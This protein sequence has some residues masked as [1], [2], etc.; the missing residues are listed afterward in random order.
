[1]RGALIGC[2]FFARNHMHAWAAL[3]GAE[4]V[5]VCDRDRAKAEAMAARFGIEGVH[6]DAAAMF[7]AL[8]LDFADVAT[9]APSH[10]PLVTLAAGHVSTVICQKPFA[11]A[12]EDAEAMVAA[13]DRA[14]AHLIVHEN[15]RWQAPLMRLKAL[16][17]AGR[18]GAPHWARVTFRHGYDNYRNQPYLMEVERFAIMD[19]GLHLFDVARWLMGEAAVTG[20]LT[21]RRNPRVAGEDAF[22][23]LLAHDRGGVSVCD[24]SFASTLDPEPFPGVGC[25]VE[26]PDGTL[27]LTAAGVLTIHGPGARR[28]EDLDPPVPPWGGR[29]WHV[30]QDSVASFQA[31]ALAVMRGEARPQPSGADNLATLRLAFDAYALAGAPRRAAP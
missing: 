6:D 31:H 25:T 30:V 17:D 2:G 19:V 7:D 15:F 13:C 1:M 5:A 3:D 9:Q 27:E 24:C 11:E 21:Q 28:V 14:G 20:C 18:I 23:A 10:R 16:T 22:T 26:G 8:E 29:P 4:I 12:I